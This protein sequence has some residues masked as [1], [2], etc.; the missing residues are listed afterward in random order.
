MTT[1]DGATRSD[2]AHGGQGALAGSPPSPLILAS[3]AEL[4]ELGRQVLDG[5]LPKARWT[6]RA[7][8]AVAAWVIGAR[9]DLVA[10]RDMP[11]MIRAYNVASGTANTDTG[12]YHETITLAS[13]QAVAAFLS[14][15]PQAMSLSA[16]CNAL[17]VS[18][19]GDPHWL[20]AHWTRD[21]LFS[22][23]ARR[24]WVEPDLQPLRF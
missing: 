5:T 23:A 20:L 24:H 16:A 10:A 8:L 17:F 11:D 21:L 13:V 18:P 1:V 19:L 6:H 12:G 4:A 14:G 9:P 3:D 22:V 2:V 7:H 15:Q